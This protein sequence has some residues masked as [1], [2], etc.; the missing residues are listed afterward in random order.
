MQTRTSK[1][2][3]LLIALAALI[4]LA[5]SVLSVMGSVSMR[6]SIRWVSHTNEVILALRG[7]C[8]TRQA[9]R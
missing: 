2:P 5:T 9:G 8:V 3:Y 6:S 4:L 7:R 1:F